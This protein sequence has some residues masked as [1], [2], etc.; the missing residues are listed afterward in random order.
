M[1]FDASSCCRITASCVGLSLLGRCLC[2][3]GR[4]ASA[5]NDVTSIPCFRLV[6]QCTWSVTCVS[7]PIEI[8]P[9]QIALIKSAYGRFR[10][11]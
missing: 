7:Y 5:V 10:N 8:H 1:L 6:A 3:A 4:C 2:R 11:L 9:R